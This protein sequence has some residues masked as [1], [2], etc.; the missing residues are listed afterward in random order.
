[1]GRFDEAI[2]LY[3]KALADILYKTPYIAENNLGWCYY[4]K[5]QVQEGIDHIKSALVPNPKF[6]LGYRNLGIILTETHQAEKAIS[7]F[8]LYAKHCPE[9]ADARYR[10]GRALLGQGDTAAARR[11]LTACVDKGRGQP[12]GE[13]CQRLLDQ[14]SP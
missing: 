13:D 2:P 5:G 3:E 8:A 1:Q 10:H 14:L 9:V 11:E 7:Y 6:C 12:V 4:K